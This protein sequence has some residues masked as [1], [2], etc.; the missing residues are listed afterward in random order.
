MSNIGLILGSTNTLILGKDKSLLCFNEISELRKILL[1]RLIFK[2]NIIVCANTKEEISNLE[3]ILKPRK[4]YYYER[5]KSILL[6]NG[7]DT[8]KIISPIVVNIDEDINIGV[9]SLGKVIINITLPI[10]KKQVKGIVKAIKK[11]IDSFSKDILSDVKEKGI[12][13][14]GN[15][16]SLYDIKEELRKSTGIPVFVSDVPNNDSINGI[17]IL[18]KDLSLLK[19]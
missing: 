16:K 5:S 15:N 9:V 6:S 3:K 8:T 12:I 11:E 19:Y 13:L 1:K 14:S 7:I 10:N 2:P 17:R 18:L 4:I